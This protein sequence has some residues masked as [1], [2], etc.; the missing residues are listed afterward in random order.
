MKI[1][2][3]DTS[4][5]VMSLAV[6][7]NQQLLGEYTTNL[8]KNHSIRLMPAIS[9]LLDELDVE[10]SALDGI[11]IAQGPGS[12]TG[13]RIGVT[14]AKSMAW[15]LGIPLVGVSSLEALA[16]NGNYFSGYVCPLF[17]A[18]R[19]Q[20]YTALF[21][22][23]ERSENDQIT[24]MESWADQ[25]AALQK[26]VLFLGDDVSMHQSVISEKLG[27]QARFGPPDW[28]VPRASYIA[29]EGSRKIQQGELSDPNLFAPRYLQLAEAE[30]K[31]LAAQ[32]AKET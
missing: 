6:I 26:P 15:S 1:L 14:T 31:W 24:M 11:A 4:N 16:G 12:Y 28:N 2:G 9:L 3:I 21:E 5:L 17:D 20:V 29:R 19:G 13:V 23:G 27:N 8:K 7:N 30:A 18:R 32:Q 10:P 22:N 25:L